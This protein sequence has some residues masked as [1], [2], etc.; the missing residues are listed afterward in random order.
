VT[1][2]ETSDLDLTWPKWVAKYQ[3]LSLRWPSQVAGP[4]VSAAHASYV[5][6]PK[7]F[8]L[9]GRATG[10]KYEREDFRTDEASH[11]SDL[12]LER[13]KLNRRLVEEHPK[14]SKFWQAF[15]RGSQ[16]CGGG[17]GFINAVWSNLAKVGFNDRDVNDELMAAQSDLATETLKLE[18]AVYRPTLIHFVTNSLGDQ[19]IFAATQI[20]REDWEPLNKD[21]KSPQNNVW[22]HIGDQR[23]ILWT[24]HP[25][26]ADTELVS[27]WNKKLSELAEV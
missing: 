25:N 8:M 15:M 24:R 17:D 1:F 19:C 4:F 20:A 26:W 18:L 2:L 12:L 23:R 27:A 7:R 6:Q 16:L 13:K 10:G 14:S 22:F 9:V 5:D 21:T 3:K 11:E